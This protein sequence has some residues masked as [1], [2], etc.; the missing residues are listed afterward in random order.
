MSLSGAVLTTQ[1]P[2]KYVLFP[3]CSKCLLIGYCCLVSEN[4][5]NVY[6]NPRVGTRVTKFLFWLK[7]NKLGH[8]V[9]VDGTFP[10]IGT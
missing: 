3:G 5:F 4:Y 2:N 8:Y 1:Q 10:K 9:Q 7:S 6:T